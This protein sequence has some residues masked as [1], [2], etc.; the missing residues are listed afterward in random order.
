VLLLIE[1]EFKVHRPPWMCALFV[2]VADPFGT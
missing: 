1:I 2:N